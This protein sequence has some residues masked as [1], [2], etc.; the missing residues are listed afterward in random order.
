M[1]GWF[2]VMVSAG[3][4][5]SAC[6]G[7]DADPASVIEDFVTAYNADDLDA[8]MELFAD[9]AMLS[10]NPFEFSDGPWVGVSIRSLFFTAMDFAAENAWTISD[11]EVDGKTVT[12]NQVYRT[13]I[14]GLEATCDNGHRAVVEGGKIESWAWPIETVECP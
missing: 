6:S 12:W 13:T 4:L 11:V 3:L 5:L 14:P 7:E 8:V 2:L 9:D 10:G 1:R